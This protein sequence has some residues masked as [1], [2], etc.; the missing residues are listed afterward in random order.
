VTVLVEEAHAPR[1]PLLARLV[2]A[3]ERRLA[4]SPDEVL[5]DYLPR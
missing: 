4:Q 2:A 3:L 5:G 1:A